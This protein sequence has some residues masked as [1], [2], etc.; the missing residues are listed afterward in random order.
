MSRIISAGRLSSALLLALALAAP[1][2]AAQTPVP[3]DSLRVNAASRLRAPSTVAGRSVEVMTRD[4]LMRLPASGLAD[5]LARSLGADLLMRSPASADL[6]IRGA[7]F[8]QVL[9]LVDGVPLRD[10]QTGHFSLDVA[11][12]LE[13]IERIEIVRGPASALYGSSAVGGIVNIVTRQGGSPARMRASAG[14]FGTVALGADGGLALGSG[15]TLAAGADATRSDGHRAGT[16]YDVL[17][18]RAATSAPLADGTLRAD[19]AWALRDF[20]A[21]RFYAPFDSRE[22][23]RSAHAGLAW[24][25]SSAAAVVLAPRLG[26]RRH[27][28]DFILRRENPSFYRN[29]HTADQFGG[30]LTAR[31]RTAGPLALAVGAEAMTS[32][33]ESTNLGTRREQRA[34]LF[35][36]AGVTANEALH[37]TAGL[38][39]DRHSAFGSFLSPSLALGLR[40]S[41]ATQLRASAARG[42]RAPNWTER[43]Y[44]DPAN[45]GTPELGPERFY[46]V[47]T[48]IT[49]QPTAA[50]RADA[51]L[52]IR[53]ARDLVDWARPTGA[54]A[55]EPWRTLN[56]ESATF[57]GVEADVQATGPLR[58]L[59]R[60][61][62]SALAVN[63]AAAAGY[64]S[65]Y[66]L[67][68]L[69][70]TLSLRAAVPLAGRFT[71]AAE[72]AHRRR[73][74]GP[75]WWHVDARTEIRVRSIT[76]VFDAVNIGDAQ[77]LDVTG[78]P[79]AGR[80]FQVGVRA[81]R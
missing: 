25:S 36:E 48:G 1:R 58:S 4:D 79:A 57:R 19:A 59:W 32:S 72:A 63:A 18:L 42:Y 68:P 78:M 31:F 16:E 80:S 22:T 12:P 23:T 60:V 44:Q 2:L 35:A 5:L 41:P 49:F 24:E 10:D 28:D 65:K 20:G 13:S 66:A 50:L 3:L 8:E 69:V 52:F 64:D 77:P 21:A 70:R 54:A 62:S 14:S 39:A 15:A 74:G 40:L 53:R 47:E 61:H 29:I 11:V 6:A 46:A 37:V 38:R 71:A 73:A 67:R 75:E 17:Q 76:L 81:G 27:G 33:L 7:S 43:Y 51:A 56:I 30:E 26:W 34:A 45:I 55:S 9:I